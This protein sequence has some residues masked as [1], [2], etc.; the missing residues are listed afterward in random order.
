MNACV[1]KQSTANSAG[2]GCVIWDKQ[3]LPAG[4]HTVTVQIRNTISGST[5]V[6]PYWSADGQTAN[7]LSV[8]YYG[9]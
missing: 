9:K 2:S 5:W 1:A 3:Y 7:T 6:T 4:T 8:M